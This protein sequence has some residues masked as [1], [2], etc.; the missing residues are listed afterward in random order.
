MK[1]VGIIPARYASTRFPGKPLADICGKPMV[2]W[3]YRQAKKSV[4]LSKV[5]VATDDSRILDVC[6]N[7]DI[8]V[9][10][11]AQ[12]PTAI[13][14]LWEVAETEDADFYVQ[15]NGDEPL[16]EPEIIDAAVP[17][18]VPAD[19]E[20]AT[21]II[22][23]VEDAVQVMDSSNIKIVFDSNMR[24]LYMSR[25]PIPYPS[26]TLNFKYHKHVGVIGWNRKMLDFYVNT[27]CGQFE[28]IE[29]C[30]L[31]RPI[32]YGKTLQLIYVPDCETLSVDTQK[33]LEE[34]IKVI[35][36]IPPPPH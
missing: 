21:N 27:E 3:V 8:P 12:H 10:L 14:R 32:E 2:W 7:E 22:T 5:V 6:K 34:V 9:V 28:S 33:D 15:I 26:K 31:M 30:D 18:F 23:N 29:G 36:I 16:I 19:T 24:A 4:K 13:H 1:V 25:T 17:D 35:S 20:Y 11:T